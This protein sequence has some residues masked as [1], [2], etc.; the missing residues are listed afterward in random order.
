MKVILHNSKSFETPQEL[1]V[2]LMEYLP[3]A[4]NDLFVD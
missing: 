1:K 3:D 2:L 4:I